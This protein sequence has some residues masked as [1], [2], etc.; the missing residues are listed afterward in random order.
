MGYKSLKEKVEPE[1]IVRKRLSADVRTHDETSRSLCL[2]SRSRRRHF[3]LRV[4]VVESFDKV[5]VSMSRGTVCVLVFFVRRLLFRRVVVFGRG[6]VSR[7]P[8]RTRSR[9]FHVRRE[10][11][12]VSSQLTSRFAP[13]E[14]PPSGP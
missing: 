3:L 10:R 2:L 12:S 11:V 8:R 7:L 9:Q 14:A 4:L 13:L 6:R 5:R 1:D